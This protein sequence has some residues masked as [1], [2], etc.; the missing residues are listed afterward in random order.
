MLERLPHDLIVLI[1]DLALPPLTSRTGSRRRFEAGRLSLI[2]SSWTP[3]AQAALFKHLRITLPTSA[4]A[5]TRLERRLDVA[6]RDGWTIQSLDLIAPGNEDDDL[7]DVF[8]AHLRHLSF[9]ANYGSHPHAQ[10]FTFSSFPSTLT[11]L[12][13]YH[14]TLT[15]TPVPAVFPY[16][17]SLILAD[18]CLDRHAPASLR[19]SDFP[20]LRSL[21][22][23]GR[24]PWDCSVDLRHAPS[25]LEHVLVRVTAPHLG[26]AEHMLRLLEKREDPLR[27]ESV[28]WYSPRPLEQEWHAHVVEDVKER[29]WARGTRF[30]F[31][32][33]P[34]EGFDY[35][36][37]AENVDS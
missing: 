21:A 11:R 12:A 19:W 30:I 3:P 13:L 26:E 16:L 9:Y 17:T 28:T 34:F 37:W 29:C 4:A 7:E 6:T 22:Y 5:R 23:N 14:L 25:T 2:H 36:A 35:E 8:Q 10:P 15:P 27:L 18:V 1:V 33:K 32:E 24:S 20:S 31:R